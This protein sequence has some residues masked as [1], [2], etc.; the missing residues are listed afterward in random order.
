MADQLPRAYTIKAIAGDVESEIPP[1]LS[2]DSKTGMMKQ[3]GRVP[4]SPTTASQTHLLEEDLC[5]EVSPLSTRGDSTGATLGQELT[6]SPLSLFLP[7][8]TPTSGYPASTHYSPHKLPTGF[9]AG[10]PSTMKV[11]R[12][13]RDTDSITIVEERL[14]EQRQANEE[15]KREIAVLRALGRYSPERLR[16]SYPYTPSSPPAYSGKSL[17]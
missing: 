6:P 12:P 7:M 4:F 5:G 14:D 9:P 17:I 11:P 16:E 2:H 13:R 10:Q 8:L 15:L 1:S 3:S